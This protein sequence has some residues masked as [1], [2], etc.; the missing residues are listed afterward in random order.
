MG[1]R[2]RYAGALA[3][4]TVLLLGSVIGC[5]FHAETFV[6]HCNADTDCDDGIECTTDTCVDTVCSNTDNPAHTPCS[7]SGVC[8]GM[9]TCLGCI[10]D[11][12]CMM[13]HSTSP[14]C[15]MKSMTCVS[16]HDGIKNGNETGTD[17]GG[18]DCG[19]CQGNP[20][21]AMNMCG[22]GTV[23]DMPENICCNMA[24]DPTITRCVTC[25]MKHGAMADGTCGAVPF[26]EDPFMQC[27]VTGTAIAGGCGATMG[28]CAC[29]DKQKNGDETDVDCGGGKCPGCGGGQMCNS[30]SDCMVITPNSP[31][32]CINGKCCESK[33]SGA[34]LACDAT[35]HCAGVPAGSTDP[36]HLCPSGTVCSE[37]T[38]SPCVATA[39]STC[40]FGGDCLSGICSTTKKTCSP[41]GPNSPCNGNAD[42]TSGNC[43]SNL[44]M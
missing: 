26:G 20:C 42:C 13:Y 27:A 25:S 30:P 17:C 16:C 23:C 31:P 11:V 22:D 12:D 1:N 7:N 15:D 18:P 29:E 24:C 5:P 36:N 2:I 39:G 40:S 32:D 34:C 43:Q 21:D 14:V 35:G 28:V 44:C 37:I 41:G 38:T 19:A 3:A 4:T 10:S 6:R 33:C 9:V 8:D